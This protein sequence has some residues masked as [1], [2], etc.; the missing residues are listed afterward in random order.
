VIEQIDGG[1][2]HILQFNFNA[3]KGTLVELMV[4][5][6]A[7]CFSVNHDNLLN[8][9]SVF[10]CVRSIRTMRESFLRSKVQLPVSRY[11]LHDA[12]PDLV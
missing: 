10:L 6:E 9:R 8:Q 4:M 1:A 11:L 5:I 12:I 7:E 2:W 3:K